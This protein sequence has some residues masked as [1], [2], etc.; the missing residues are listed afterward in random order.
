MIAA[1]RTPKASAQKK[2][3]IVCTVH[4]ECD[5]IVRH[6]EPVP[7]NDVIFTSWIICFRGFAVQW[8]IHTFRALEH[9]HVDGDGNDIVCQHVGSFE[10]GKMCVEHV[11]IEIECVRRSSYGKH[12]PPS[13][14]CCGT[15][16]VDHSKKNKNYMRTFRIFWA[17]RRRTKDT[18]EKCIQIE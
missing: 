9:V 1:K 4:T 7:K 12:R 11:D 6:W 2:H 3:F 13:A 15:E 5:L 14:V 18:H 8:R 16:E 10:M 17:V